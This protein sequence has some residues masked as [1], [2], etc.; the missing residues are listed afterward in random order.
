MSKSE[1][2]SITHVPERSSAP[3]WRLKAQADRRF[4]SGHPWIYSN[5][6]QE[7]PKG[8]P[9]GALIELH[10]A[11]GKFLARGY[12][13]PSSLI[14]FRALSRDAE[15]VTPDS[16]ASLHAALLEA[17]QVR[18]A[19][20]LGKELSHRLC[21][22]EA[23]QLQGLV[24]DRPIGLERTLR[25]SPCS[26]TAAGTDRLPRHDRG[27]RSSNCSLWAPRSARE[28]ELKTAIV[29]R[30]DVGMPQARGDFHGS[31]D[32]FGLLVVKTAA[33]VDLARPVTIRVAAAIPG[34]EIEFSVDLLEGQKTGFFLDQA[35]NIEL[36]AQRLANLR[37]VPR[38]RPLLLRRPSGARSSPRTFRAKGIRL[39][40]TA[41]S[42]LLRPRRSSARSMLNASRPRRALRNHQDRHRRPEALAGLADRSFSIWSSA[43]RPRAE[44]RAART[45]RPAR[46]L[47]PASSSTPR[48]SAWSRA[49]RRD[50]HPARCSGLLEEE[51]FLK[52]LSK[53]A[54]RNKA[55]CPLD[56]AGEP[57]RRTIRCGS[58]SPRGVI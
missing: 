29:L 17:S 36:A 10:D 5:E 31:K 35:A 7:S 43:I 34:E 24:I 8:I 12:G 33:G 49:R 1:S 9:P 46:M 45:S 3:I 21:F 27:K 18:D 58:S 14:A 51:D 26:C 47:S 56:R 54:Y 22:A 20:G 48:P 37:V 39:E 38:P 44:S 11:G 53:A 52:S 2:L 4:R 55:E 32:A 28:L 13:N 57:S 40:V 30:N 23:D 15:N 16:A 42:M 50:R 6:L 41:S 19:L 25:F